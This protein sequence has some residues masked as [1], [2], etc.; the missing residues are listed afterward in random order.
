[1]IYEQDGTTAHRQTIVVMC[2]KYDGK[3][4]IYM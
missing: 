4:I 3:T 2:G 1:M